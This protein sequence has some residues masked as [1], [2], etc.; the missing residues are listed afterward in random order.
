MAGPFW[1]SF[2]ISV[3]CLLS[4][5]PGVELTTSS[6]LIAFLVDLIRQSRYSHCA[7]FFIQEREGRVDNN[8]LKDS[9]IRDVVTSVQGV[10]Y[11]NT[12]FGTGSPKAGNFVAPEVIYNRTADVC[13]LVLVLVKDAKLEFF[14][15]IK[16]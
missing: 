3:T 1:S 2:A 14:Q 6:Q 10:P 8:S 15:E 7:L 16:K 5:I 4:L 12:E 11:F 13:K 9:F